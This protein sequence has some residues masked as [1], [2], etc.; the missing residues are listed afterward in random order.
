MTANDTKKRAKKQRLAFNSRQDLGSDTGSK[1]SNRKRMGHISRG[2]AEGM[3][4]RGNE[5]CKSI[6]KGREKADGKS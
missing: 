2:Q 5:E 3:K 4:R 6:I 1:G